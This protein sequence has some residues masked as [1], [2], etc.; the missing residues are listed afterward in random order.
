MTY[1]EREKLIRKLNQN[2]NNTSLGSPNECEHDFD[3]STGT[4]YCLTGQM[5]IPERVVKTSLAFFR[6]EFNNCA[7]DPEEYNKA[8]CL[9]V[10]IEAITN[11]LNTKET[12]IIFKGE[13]NG[14]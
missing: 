3:E 10:A 12:K 9:S 7:S 8:V 5:Q 14:N 2:F 1:E 4:Y 6:K 11:Y 13:A